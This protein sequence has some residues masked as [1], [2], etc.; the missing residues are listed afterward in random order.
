MFATCG[1]NLDINSQRLQSHT[2]DCALLPDELSYA[3]F[4][5]MLY[6]K[7]HMTQRPD[8]LVTGFA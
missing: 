6:Y 4:S 7:G 8:V 1:V 2:L 5:S 3:G